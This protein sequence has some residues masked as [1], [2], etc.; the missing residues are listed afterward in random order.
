MNHGVREE[1]LLRRELGLCVCG[2][3]GGGGVC[4][5]ST[6]HGMGSCHVG[7]WPRLH[8]GSDLKITTYKCK[9]FRRR[10]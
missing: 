6:D 4:Y 10:A 3:G 9:I 5:L 7:K 8:Q 2:G 1:R